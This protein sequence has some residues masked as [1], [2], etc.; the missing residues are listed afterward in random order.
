[1][2]IIKNYYSLHQRSLINLSSST[3]INVIH[4]MDVMSL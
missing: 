2:H 3:S 1:V 4:D